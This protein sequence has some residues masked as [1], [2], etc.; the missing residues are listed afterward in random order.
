MPTKSK[1][2]VVNTEKPIVFLSHS[3]K[4][5]DQLNALKSLLDERLGGAVE[6]FLSSDGESIPLGRN[7]ISTIEDA[8]ERAGLMFIFLS[9][10]SL[11]SKWVHFEAGNAYAKGVD[12]VPVCLP[13][14]DF[15]VVAAPLSILQ[16]FNLHSHAALGNLV[17]KCNKTFDLKMSKAF[18]V[19]DYHKI[20]AA[21]PLE[22]QSYFGRWGEHVLSVELIAETDKI[23]W[24]EFQPVPELHQMYAKRSEFPEKELAFTAY[25]GTVLELVTPGGHF[26]Q[27]EV[28][29]D[30]DTT[31]RFIARFAPELFHRHT[32]ILDLWFTENAPKFP[33]E[34]IVRLRNVSAEYKPEI[35][36]AR[37]FGSDVTLEKG[38]RYQFGGINFRYHQDEG[39]PT[40]RFEF[41]GEL[42]IEPVRELLSRLFSREVFRPHPL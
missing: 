18:T 30:S 11:D 24:S 20:F 35:V 41:C 38:G 42:T 12:V 14:L 29:S 4:D 19:E 10:N 37:L 9:K 7:W 3:S 16:G 22:A 36:S 15:N 25:S 2:K 31:W 8:L 32:F 33:I 5:R 23:H 6:F 40:I 21:S 28:A 17:E 34:T 13:G 27:D 26:R 39:S 1:R